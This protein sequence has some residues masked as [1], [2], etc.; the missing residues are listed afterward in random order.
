M[1]KLSQLF[2]SPQTTHQQ[3]ILS[4]E[5]S[6]H[7]VKVLRMKKN[8]ELHLTDGKG[9]LFLAKIAE[10][11]HK[12]CVLDIVR[13]IEQT[14]APLYHIHVAIAPTKNI[15]R[16]EWFVEK[17]VE[18]G[19][20]QISFV[21]CNRS[22]RKQVKLP[23]IQKIALSAMKQS[24]KFFMPQINEMVSFK[25]FM[26]NLTPD[27]TRYVAH[28]NEGERVFLKDVAQKHQ[29]Y[30][31]LIGPEGDFTPDEVTLALNNEFKA[32]SLGNSRLRTETA[33]I[34]A[35]HLLNIVNE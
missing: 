18:F 22:E 27:E 11:H 19:I 12:K 33:G 10:P 24:L 26:A 31:I 21:Q 1:L 9:N 29:K 28:L 34:A 16:I 8:D 20:Q 5:E 7:C 3:A 15:D 6:R 4:E 2:Y 13:T 35:C 32:V 30:C 17:S 14:P 25:S 23:R